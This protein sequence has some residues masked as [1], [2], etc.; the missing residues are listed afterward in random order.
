[1]QSF[2]RNGRT[3][4]NRKCGT[5]KIGS[6]LESLELLLGSLFVLAT[7]DSHFLCSTCCN[8][9]EEVQRTVF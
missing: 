6:N 3:S 8:I 4:D 2:G 7:G 5:G 1:M 9:S